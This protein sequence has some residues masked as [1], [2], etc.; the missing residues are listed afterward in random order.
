MKLL[1]LI[2]F[3]HFLFE[4][5]PVDRKVKEIVKDFEGFFDIDDEDSLLVETFKDKALNEVRS[6]AIFIFL[7]FSDSDFEKI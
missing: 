3:E 6:K 2:H 4:D 1:G 5:I 7:F